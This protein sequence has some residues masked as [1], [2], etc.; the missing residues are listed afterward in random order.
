MHFDLFS[1]LKITL[2]CV[3]FWGC[4]LSVMPVGAV[5][6]VYQCGQ[7][8]TNQPKNPELCQKIEIS[9]HT[10]IDGTKVQNQTKPTP[11]PTQASPAS[12]PVERPSELTQPVLSKPQDVHHRNTQARTILEDERQKLMAQHAELV[13]NFNQGQPALLEGESPHQAKYLQRVAGLKSN[14][15]RIERDLQALQREIARYAAP[16]TTVQAK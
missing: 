2:Q 16:V 7:E 4:A 11:V 15:L 10:Q 3:M 5:Q 1:N 8:V 6:A 12:A 9:N 13:R 14:L